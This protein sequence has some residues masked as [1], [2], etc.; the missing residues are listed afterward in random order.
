MKPCVRCGEPTPGSYCPA[1]QPK[2]NDRARDVSRDTAAWQKLSKRARRLQPFCT[3]CGS[4]D[5]LQTDHTPRAWARVEAKKILR[6]CDCV[7][8]CRVCNNT[9]GSSKPGSER[10]KAWEA[11]GESLNAKTP[12]ETWRVALTTQGGDPGGTRSPLRGES[13]NP[14]HTPRGYPPSNTGGGYA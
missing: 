7:V 14:L 1:C 5:D 3:A 8:L 4:T 9:A 13:Q 6:L 10:Y 11:L 12:D 2:R